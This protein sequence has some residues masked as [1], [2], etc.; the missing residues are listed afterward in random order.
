MSPVPAALRCAPK[1]HAATSAPPQNSSKR[2]VPSVIRPHPTTRAP[3]G[4]HTFP[5][6][7]PVRSSPYREKATSLNLQGPLGRCPCN[8]QI[9]LARI[10]EGRLAL[11]Q[12]GQVQP[13][14]V[15]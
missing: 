5:C 3:P 12:A 4:T 6:R 2:V 8:G 10:L 7:Q 13:P 14:K 15:P 9:L 11:L 1:V